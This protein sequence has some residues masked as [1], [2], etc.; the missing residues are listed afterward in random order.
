ME[1]GLRYRS[2]DPSR[3][4]T[5]EPQY[6]QRAAKGQGTTVTQKGR[7]TNK[8]RYLQRTKRKKVCGEGGVE[9]EDERG[10]CVFSLWFSVT[11]GSVA[12]TRN[13]TG[14]NKGRGM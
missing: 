11:F 10:L 4:A 14:K 1:G 9:F 3:S 6:P 8:A 2:R 13:F 7:P 5:Q 12:F